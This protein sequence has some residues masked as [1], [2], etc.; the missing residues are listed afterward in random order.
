MTASGPRVVAVE[1]PAASLSAVERE[2]HD[3]LIRFVSGAATNVD[4]ATFQSWAARDRAHIEAF[5]TVCRM[6]EGVEPANALM[7]ASASIRGRQRRMGRRT[8]V[9]GAIAASA[10]GYFSV[11]PPL[12]LWPSVSEL[13]ADYRTA[14]GEQRRI[15]LPSGPSVELNTRTSIALLPSEG[16][17]GRFRLI[18]GEASVSTRARGSIVRVEAGN[19]EIG[20]NDAIFNVRY[21][22]G[23]VRTTC[24]E[25]EARVA[26]GGRSARIGAGDQIAYSATGLG[27][28]ARV[29]ATSVTAWRSGML[30]FEET[31]LAEA[32]AEIN[33]YRSRPIILANPALGRRLFNAQFPI[34]S[35]EGVAEQ[36]KLVFGAHVVTLPGGIVLLS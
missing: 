23:V 2:A 8:F 13:A 28:G 33:R 35:V 30:T 34:A 27:A 24:I 10:A 25:G 16:G 19:G 22:A 6:W 29:D 20:S 11:R 21:E 31:P 5:D 12:G 1:N 14:P 9:G 36:I 15:T 17:A 32:I 3:W 26:S 7:M 18:A 4:L